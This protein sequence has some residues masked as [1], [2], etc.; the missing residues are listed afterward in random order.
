MRL[1]DGMT[2]IAYVRRGGGM[3]RGGEGEGGGVLVVQKF[4]FGN[5]AKRTG[6]AVWMDGCMDQRA[7][8]KIFLQ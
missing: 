8:L 6:L 7:H 1:C 2:N 4:R 3:E 5:S